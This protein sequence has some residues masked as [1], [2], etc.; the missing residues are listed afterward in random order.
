MSSFEV[1]E[2]YTQARD[3]ERICLMGTPGCG[4]TQ[5][6]G[7]IPWSTKKWGDRGIYIA[8]DSGSAGLD[9]VLEDDRKHLIPVR[10][11]PKTVKDPKT[12]EERLVVDVNEFMS[13]ALATNWKARYP[14]VG[15]LIVDTFTEPAQTVL[16]AIASANPFG[17]G[18]VSYGTGI[19]QVNL[20]SMPDYGAAQ[21]AVKRWIQLAF[22]QPLNLVALFHGDFVEPEQG[23]T[24]TIYGGPAT[25]GKALVRYIAGKFHNVFLVESR[26][27][28]VRVGNEVKVQTKYTV[29]TEQ[30]G[31][32]HAKM[33]LG[34]ANPMP[35][36]DITNN[37]RAFWQ[38]YDAAK[39]T[40]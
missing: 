12:G 9:S 32:W 39:E 3:W 11:I 33:R 25:V 37:Q 14:D 4:K 8:A 24:G 26:N 1:I 5:L 15:T 34:R 19:S 35:S 10:L 22:N 31:I 17:G 16:A 7:A 36:F 2:D 38:A 6:A 13:Q 23:E 28:S 40:N 29:Y 21:A 20:P 27:S 18:H 30:K